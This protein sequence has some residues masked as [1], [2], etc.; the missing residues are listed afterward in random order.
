MKHTRLFIFLV[1]LS[2][3]LQSFVAFCE[4]E[5]LTDTPVTASHV[6]SSGLTVGSGGS[7]TGGAGSIQIDE[8]M[9]AA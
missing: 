4:D 5:G 1:C 9:G 6:N 7:N 8:F 3:V 2:L